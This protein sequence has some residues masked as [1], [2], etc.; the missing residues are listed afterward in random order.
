MYTYQY[1][2]FWS[3]H[4]ALQA[5]SMSP[6]QMAHVWSIFCFLPDLC[7]CVPYHL[8]KCCGWSFHCSSVTSVGNGSTQHVALQREAAQP[9]R[10]RITTYH[11]LWHHRSPIAVAVHY[12]DVLAP[13]DEIKEVQRNDWWGLYE[14]VVPSNIP[15]DCRL[16]RTHIDSICY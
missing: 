6:C 1:K 12:S 2:H 5:L 7:Q 11:L 4:S 8:C 15:E 3:F 9:C 13:S 14:P 16:Y 10:A